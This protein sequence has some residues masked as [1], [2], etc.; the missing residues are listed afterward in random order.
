MFLN[1]NWNLISADI[2][3]TALPNNIRILW[4]YDDG[5]WSAYSPIGSIQNIINQLPSIDTI[6]SI[7]VDKGTWVLSDID[8]NLSILENNLSN[9]T[10]DT[11]GW[12]LLGV[13]S[14]TSISSFSCTNGDIQSIWKYKNK[15]WQLNTNASNSLNLDSFDTIDANE[16]FWVLCK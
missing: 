1:Q 12:H 9:T 14:D 8:Q 6:S 13:G 15:K 7:S 5:K 2:N 11:N 10:I 16:G 4:Q 3:L